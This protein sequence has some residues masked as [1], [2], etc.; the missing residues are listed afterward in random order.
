MKK[1]SYKPMFWLIVLC[2]VVTA[3]W[4]LFLPDM[5]PMHYGPGGEA[6]RFGSKYE[7]L[8]L[9]LVAAVMGLLFRLLG[10]RVALEP[11]PGTEQVVAAVFTIVLAF[12]NL[13]NIFFLYKASNYVPNAASNP[14]TVKL[15]CIAI[16]VLLVVLCNRMP[17]APMNSAFGLRTRWSMKSPEIWRRCQRFGGYSG[18]LCG[19]LLIL[20]GALFSGVT[21]TAVLLVVVILWGV[22]T[23][24]ASYLISKRAD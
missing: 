24:V 10:K 11:Q 22:G 6:D 13:L 7:M 1:V 4:L 9:P 12:F 3:V 17:K 15:V 21:A 14:D 19:L 8:I 2:F 16:G 20:C 5:V 23:T 18:I